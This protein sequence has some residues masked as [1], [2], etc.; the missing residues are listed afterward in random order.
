MF[1]YKRSKRS[2]VIQ[3]YC[4]KDYCVKEV[5]QIK[6][7]EQKAYRA[8]GLLLV[9]NIK[10]EEHPYYASYHPSDGAEIVT[11][12]LFVIEPNKKLL[13]GINNMKGKAL[14]DIN[15]SKMHLNIPGGKR[16]N[17]DDDA[18]ATAIR[19]FD[20]ETGGI[21]GKEYLKTLV[22]TNMADCF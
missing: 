20:E 14:F 8:A 15:Y 12:G 17:K 16:D 4:A 5:E 2:N 19:E 7:T 11:Q 10:R 9:R 18:M 1:C 22:E 6:A 13:R 21:I 3:A